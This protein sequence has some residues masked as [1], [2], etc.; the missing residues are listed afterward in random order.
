[1]DRTLRDTMAA[2]SGLE[3][4]ITTTAPIAPAAFRSEIQ[5]MVARLRRERLATALAELAD[6][7]ANPVA[8][9]VVALTLAANG[10]AQDL[11]ELLGSLSAAARDGAT[12]RLRIDASRARTRT[13]V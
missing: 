12:M 10:E 8:D 4:A 9:L 6:S 11:G 3:Q 7:L 13:S 2:A 5:A 1:M